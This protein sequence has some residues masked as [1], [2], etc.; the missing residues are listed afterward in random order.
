MT[1]FL[2]PLIIFIIWFVFGH[3]RDDV[4]AIESFHSADEENAS[5]KQVEVVRK[6][7]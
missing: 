5:E 3:S 1:Y 6:S 7:E 4:S 2:I